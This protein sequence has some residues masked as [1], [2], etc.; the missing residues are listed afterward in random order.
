[1]KLTNNKI[2]DYANALAGAFNDPDLRL[3]VKVNF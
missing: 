2:Y 1:M 3:P